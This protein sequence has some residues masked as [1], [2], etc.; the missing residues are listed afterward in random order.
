M[1][2]DTLYVLIVSVCVIASCVLSFAIGD[3]RKEKGIKH[4]CDTFGKVELS[5]VVYVCNEEA[6]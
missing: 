6:K 5:G 3:G 1:D 2:D 4:M